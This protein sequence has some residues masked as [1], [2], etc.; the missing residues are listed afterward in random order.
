MRL[1]IFFLM[2]RAI[3]LLFFPSRKTIT[4]GVNRENKED[5][6]T[7]LDDRISNAEESVQDVILKFL[8]EQKLSLVS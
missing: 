1:F 8:N 2:F 3:H 5:F 4:R 7:A 6:R